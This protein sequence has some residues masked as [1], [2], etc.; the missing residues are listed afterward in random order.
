MRP[1][2][3]SPIEPRAF[4]AELDDIVGQHAVTHMWIR[5]DALEQ[6]FIVE[7][8]GIHDD[9][10]YETPDGE[11]LRWVAVAAASPEPREHVLGEAW[12][13]RLRAAM[14]DVHESAATYL[15]IKRR[16][17]PMHAFLLSQHPA[18]YQH[19]Y[20]TI[21]APVDAV[22][23]SSYVQ[24][25]VGRVLVDVSLSSR[26][27]EHF[28]GD[29]PPDRLPPEYCG[30][31][32]FMET[33]AVFGACGREL[34]RHVVDWARS[35]AIPAAGREIDREL[36]WESLGVEDRRTLEAKLRPLVHGFIASRASE[37]IPVLER[38]RWSSV[39]SALARVIELRF[40][41]ALRS[42]AFD[43]PLF[44]PLVQA[45][46]PARYRR[47]LREA[48]IRIVGQ[49]II[50]P[51]ALPW[52]QITVL[53]G[54]EP[55]TLV[56]DET[57]DTLW[58]AARSHAPQVAWAG[59]LRATYEQ[60]VRASP[61]QELTL[62]VNVRAPRPGHD[63]EHGDALRELDRRGVGICF[64]LRG[65]HLAWLEWLSQEPGVRLETRSLNGE[66]DVLVVPEESA[67]T[68]RILTSPRLPGV[69]IR[70]TATTASASLSE[71]ELALDS[72][73]RLT[74]LCSETEVERAWR[75]LPLARC[76]RNW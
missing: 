35:E 73:G 46:G 13:S 26:A 40:P 18:A 67:T 12:S 7:H 53:Q 70:L 25:I 11:L 71:S 30:D 6:A 60:L 31:G 20:D 64:Y 23:E 65:S 9:L 14:I 49:P 4:A 75:V 42:S 36:F 54:V 69:G 56:Q 41:A 59:R 33:L 21:A 74:P 52:S 63:L 50:D 24:W 38:L 47:A 27:S 55:V 48:E 2:S 43:W 51:E 34:G 45:I 16:P 5:R 1:V 66:A 32:R 28:Q 68:L 10:I 22:F 44:E 37:R 58:L 62:V 17:P 39:L 61:G 72:L 76:W 57:D 8:E 15:S 29:A 3:R 19:Y